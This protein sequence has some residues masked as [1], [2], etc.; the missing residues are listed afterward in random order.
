MNRSLGTTD[1]FSDCQHLLIIPF[2]KNVDLVNRQVENLMLLKDELFQLKFGL[3]FINDSPSHEDH[4]TALKKGTELLKD[5]EFCI[6]YIENGVNM[7][8]VKSSN[9]GLNIAA[10]LGVSA[11]LVNSDAFIAQGSLSEMR[12]LLNAEEKIGFVG[13]RSN[14]ASIASIPWDVDI[15]SMNIKEVEE[16]AQKA[17]SRLPR[18]QIVPVVPGSV[19]WIKAQVLKSVGVFDEIFS[20]G[21]N[22]ENDLEMRSNQIGYIAVLANH[23]FAYHLKSVSF[24]SDSHKLEKRHSTVLEERYPWY[25]HTIHKYNGS[26]Q[27]VYERLLVHMSLHQNRPTVLIDLS[28][29]KPDKTGTTFVTLNLLKSIYES[30]QWSE[31]FDITILIGNHVESYHGLG[32]LRNKFNVV[33]LISHRSLADQVFWARIYFS[34]PFLVQDDFLANK[35]AAINIYYFLDNIA[36]DCLYLRNQT[37]EIELYWRFIAQNANSLVFLT[38]YSMSNFY[39]RFDRKFKEF[40]YVAMPS[41][42]IDE[43]IKPVNSTSQIPDKQSI[44]SVDDNAPRARLQILIVGNKFFHKRAGKVSA[45]LSNSFKDISILELGAGLENSSIGSSSS[46]VKHVSGQLSDADVANLY[47][48]ADLII[49]PTNYEGFGFPLMESIAHNKHI[50]IFELEVFKEVIGHMSQMSNVKSSIENIHMVKDFE[51]LSEFVADFRK[52]DLNPQLPKLLLSQS[53]DEDKSWK[54]TNT[55]AVFHRALMDSLGDVKVEDKLR[56]RLS[57]IES[58]ELNF[59]PAGS[60]KT[61]AIAFRLVRAFYRRMPTGVQQ[62]LK[63]YRNLF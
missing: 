46:V 25:Y 26:I 3:I 58:M 22:E 24:G 62:V 16:L 29:L 4:R 13:P 38:E 32:Y 49:F 10:D 36:Y 37:P 60:S 40:D 47:E 53:K 54:W 5:N 50:V 2:Y 9:I 31:H 20:P 14:E 61:R 59:V 11:L 19:L 57:G 18:Y 12:E 45:L 30:D 27:R 8:F 48:Q 33:D 28:Y 44:S 42:D 51:E 23:A 52:K 56:Q 1:K 41:C 21:Y 35:L 43:Y 7:G 34:Q 6:D 15:E 39:F 55:V 17:T 63:K